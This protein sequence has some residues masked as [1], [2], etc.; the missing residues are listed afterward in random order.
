MRECDAREVARRGVAALVQAAGVRVAHE[1]HQMLGNLYGRR[2]CVLVGPGLN[3]ADGR[4]AASTL[5]ARGSHVDVV[6]V[7]HQP[8]NFRG[9]DLVIDAAFGLGC[10]RPYLAPDVASGTLVL[11][12]DLPSGVDADTGAVLGRPLQANVTLALGALKYAHFDGVAAAYCGE[13]RFASIGIDAPLDNALI[14]DSDL[15]T[16]VAMQ[17]DDHKWTH[18]ISVLA[19][20]SRMPGAAAL[21]CAGALSAG[22]SMVRLESKG[23]I[24]AVVT[25]PVEVVRARGPEVDPR[26][27]CVVAGPGLGNKA[28]SWLRER[29]D[30]TS[31]ATV[32]D[33]DALRMD[34]VTMRRHAPRVL[35]PHRGEFERMSASTLGSNRITAVREL[36]QSTHCIVL[37]KGPTTIIADPEGHVR[38]VTSGTPTLASAGTGD[39]LSGMIGAAIA[40]G[41]HPLEAASLSAHLHGRASARLGT[42][43]TA[44]SLAGAVRE[45]LKSRMRIL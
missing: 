1:A 7:D 23:E 18:A 28:G 22:A 5:R 20:S 45:E 12:V 10:S 3:G 29:L 17:H 24:A 38:V 8:R 13:V 14:E 31:L 4:A 16:Y 40:R 44:S 35:T 9:F 37:L 43:E 39:V 36:A 27:R 19:G 25:L 2:I 41:H 15:D 33:A 32:F 6:S 21:V 42:F 26:S 34:L 11:A 30:D